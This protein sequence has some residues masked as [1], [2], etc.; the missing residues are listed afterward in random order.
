MGWSAFRK[1]GLTFHNP[2][3]TVKGYTLFVQSADN[4]IYLLN[5]DGKIVEQWQFPG[6]N[7]SSAIL[8][9]NGN[10]LISGTETEFA[11]QAKQIEPDDFSNLDYHL[12]R[13]GGGY[14]TLRE[15]DFDGNLIWS[16]DN[17]AIHHDF[18]VC[19]NGDILLP[20]WVVLEPE[21]AKQVRGG[22]RKPGRQGQQPPMLGDDIIRINRAGEEVGRWHLW[23]MLDPRKDPIGP[24]QSRTEWTHV[25]SIDM[26]ADGQ[27]LVSC[28]QTSSVVLID[29]EQHKVTW[30]I[31]SPE[32]SVQHNARS[33]PNGNIQIFDNGAYR[34]AASPYSQII[35][36]DPRTDEIVWRY[37]PSTHEQFFSGHL[38]SAQRLD[39]GNVLICEGTPGRLFEVTRKGEVVWEWITPI[40]TGSPDGRIRTWIYRAF[41]YSVSHPAFADREMNP[42]RYRQMNVAYGLL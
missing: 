16:Y 3:S 24:L 34:P 42:E 30:K 11:Q 26:M 13:L 6:F 18:H 1:T 22:Y 20:E 40:V 36:V 15:Y 41:R 35:E 31:G 5:M 27:L 37:Q 28:R 14:T 29:P 33:L 32:I 39:L 9:D 21:F 2:N 23:Q 38:S 12:T 25:N 4:H 19:E 8:L 17:R 7:P 10:L